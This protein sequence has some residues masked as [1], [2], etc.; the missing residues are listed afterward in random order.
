MAIPVNE[1]SYN[2]VAKYSKELANFVSNL[3]NDND[4][5]I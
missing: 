5:I 1:D 4:V 2:N 3:K